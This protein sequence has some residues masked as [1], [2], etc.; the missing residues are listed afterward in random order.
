[1]P[2]R[3]RRQLRPSLLSLRPLF[4]PS[5]VKA[6][7]NL[8]WSLLVL[9]SRPWRHEGKNGLD[10]FS[11]L[12]RNQPLDRTIYLSTIHSMSPAHFRWP[13]LEQFHNDL[14]QVMV[15]SYDKW[16]V[17]YTMLKLLGSVFWPGPRSMRGAMNPSFAT[18]TCSKISSYFCEFL[19][20]PLGLQCVLICGRK[21]KQMRDMLGLPPAEDH[22]RNSLQCSLRTEDSP[23]GT[24]TS[25]TSI[26]SRRAKILHLLC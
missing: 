23:E 26:R 7:S 3:L 1:M 22:S 17:L 14:E 4:R 6:T 10:G 19:A 20:I 25:D 9:R 13:L 21:G 11:D 15:P 5:R 2:L 18:V 8:P 16:G 24:L 12:N